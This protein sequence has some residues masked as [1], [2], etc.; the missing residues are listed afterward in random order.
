MKF[1][2]HKKVNK[3]R[4]YIWKVTWVDG[5]YNNVSIQ[6]S[7]CSTDPQPSH[8]HQGPAAA[9]DGGGSGEVVKPVLPTPRFLIVLSDVA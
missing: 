9:G 3:A 4:V 1:I 6:Y 7:H 2:N 5:R 8:H